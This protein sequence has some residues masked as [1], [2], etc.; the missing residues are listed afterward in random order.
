[1]PRSRCPMRVSAPNL[2]SHHAII[3]STCDGA[4]TKHVKFTRMLCLS[5]LLAACLAAPAA[6]HDA[7]SQADSRAWQHGVDLIAV[8]AKLLLVWG[9]AG[10]PP[11]PNLGGDWPHD[12]FYAWLDPADARNAVLPSPR[13]LVAAQEAQEPPSIAINA[14]GT[15]LLTTEDGNGG[16]NQRAG[17]WDSSLREIRQ[18][19][20]TIRR[21]GHSGH[22]AA[23]GNQFLVVYGEGWVNGGGWQD[24]GTGKDVYARV[25]GHDGRLQAET[26]L[27]SPANSRTTGRFRDSWPLVAASDRNWLAVWQRYPE[28]TLQAALVDASGKVSKRIRIIDG[29]PLRYSYDVAFSPQLDAFVVAGN[30]SDGGFVSLISP[31]G[32]LLK[33]RRGLPRMASESRIILR[34]EGDGSIG[35]Y[36][37]LP[38]GIAVLRLSAA[39]IDLV[40]V[41]AHPH[42]W[43]YAGTSGIFL[44]PEQVLFATLS[45]AGLHLIRADL[46][47]FPDKAVPAR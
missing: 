43:D 39:A 13:V 34:A 32:D 41:I 31:G 30:S 28:L 36:P 38:S 23:M 15:L 3:E 1:M 35:A 33:T 19:P 5:L 10:N 46:D 40:K 8:G 25:V 37:S 2:P 45:R 18:Y 44:A 14:S 24:L 42:H 26:R 27:A 16:I 21:G 7:K 12:I 20:F 47:L 11:R 17:M 4:A 9:S 22:V 29:L 6:E